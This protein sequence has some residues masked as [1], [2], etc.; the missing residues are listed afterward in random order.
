MNK[1]ESKESPYGHYIVKLFLF[2]YESRVALAQVRFKSS[3][4]HFHSDLDKEIEMASPIM[5][6]HFDFSTLSIF[7][8]CGTDNC[9]PGKCEEHS[10]NV[11]QLLAINDYLEETYFSV[12][13]LSL[14][15][16][17]VHS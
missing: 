1:A 5:E 7:L 9:H 10:Q 8:T 2:C 11:Q 4:T 16:A 13:K 17:S 12:F 3:S 6:Y 14:I 15:G